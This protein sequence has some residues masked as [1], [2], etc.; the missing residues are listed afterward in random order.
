MRSVCVGGFVAGWF[1]FAR[2]V[3][4][5]STCL[6]MAAGSETFQSIEVSSDRSKAS[7]GWSVIPKR[8]S[9]SEQSEEESDELDEMGLGISPKPMDP[10]F[11]FPVSTIR[12]RYGL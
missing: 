4:L 2:N 10:S 5:P 8:W 12:G 1:T 11:P 6:A 7:N 3:A 9:E